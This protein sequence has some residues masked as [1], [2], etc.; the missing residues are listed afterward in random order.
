MPVARGPQINARSAILVGLT[1][2]IIALVLGGMVL[3]VARSSGDVQIQLGDAQF[4]AGFTT[5]QAEEIDAR[6]PI[7]YADAGS[8][9]QRDL[10]V[11]HVGDDPDVGWLAFSARRVGD[12][13]DC[14]V[15]WDPATA[16]FS[17]V[18]STDRVCDDVTFDELGC[19]LVRYPVEVIDDKVIVFLNE[20]A[21]EVA[22]AVGDGDDDPA[23]EG[24]DLSCA[25]E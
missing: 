1:G 7:L 21:E 25:D 12:P 17:M 3:W 6:G 15:V 23:P 2:V 8:S 18:S 14:S 24:P 19:G 16:T 22:A 4:D 13:R 9:G 20:T 11:Q 5:R 10:Y